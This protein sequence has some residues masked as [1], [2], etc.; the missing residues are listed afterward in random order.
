[1]DKLQFVVDESIDKSIVERLKENYDLVYIDGP[2]KGTDD[3]EVLRIAEEQNRILI[4]ADKDFGEMVFLSNRLHAG[5]ILCRL[6]GLPPEHKVSLV[7][8]VI[9]KIVLN[10]C[11]LSQ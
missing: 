3:D 10:Y 4:I 7:D 8:F 6:H 1:M 2:L 5:I 11:I 9:K